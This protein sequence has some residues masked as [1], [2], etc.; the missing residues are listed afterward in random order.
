MNAAAVKFMFVFVALGLITGALIY[1]ISSAKIQPTVNFG[2]NPIMTEGT[3]QNTTIG[4][5]REN[6]QT[7][8]AILVPGLILVS[9]LV[10]IGAVLAFR[11]R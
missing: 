11:R 6:V 3:Q 10:I 8:S 1:S 7:G 2:D 9:A 5:M 4:L